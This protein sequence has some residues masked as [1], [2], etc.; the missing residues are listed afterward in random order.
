[1]WRGAKWL[2]G[3]EMARMRISCAHRGALAPPQHSEQPRYY[4]NRATAIRARL[5]T[6]QDDEVFAELYLLAAYYERLAEF[7]K[8]SGPFGGFSRR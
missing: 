6:L 8:S 2:G 5:P 1:M 4:R 3:A 7:A